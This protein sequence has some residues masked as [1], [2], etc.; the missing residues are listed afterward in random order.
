[1]KYFIAVAEELHFGHAAERLHMAQ[2]PLSQ[3]IK[4][5][6]EELGVQLLNRTKRKVELTPAGKMFLD[7]ARLT[8]LQADRA[9][10][11]ATE[12][13]QGVRGRLR[14]G[15]VT[16]ASYSILPILV[17]RYRREN[18]LV[19]LELLEMTPSRQIE[20]LEKKSIDVGL[21]RP[22][23][24]SSCLILKT[25]LEEPLVV[26]LPSDHRMAGQKA[27]SLKSLAEDAFV[28][29]PRHH[30]PGIY[31]VIM[32]ACH[33]AGFIPQVSYSPNEMQTI[34][35]YV[36]AGLGISLVPQSLSG[37]HSGSIVYLPLRG[38]R[39]KVEL[40]LLRRADDENPLL[41]A[42]CNLS[43]E[44]GVEYASQFRKTLPGTL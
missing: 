9:K 31:D 10:R 7:E 21:L 22:P 20:A 5:L 39:A 19:D 28:L 30:G 42:F 16:S 34:L 12:A 43:S 13:S 36:A 32:K 18:T 26:A 8:L 29:F 2:P 15:F 4:K 35:A 41:R 23:V 38:S 40:A 25:L 6:E 1:M 33:E 14:V 37:F 3:Q 44:V 17:R 11:I 27:V 24:G